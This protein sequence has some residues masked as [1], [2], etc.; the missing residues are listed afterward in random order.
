MNIATQNSRL[1]IY[2]AL[3]GSD[4]DDPV[5]DQ[6]SEL[7]VAAEEFCG[8]VNPAHGRSEESKFHVKDQ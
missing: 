4:G 5:G 7:G 8:N 6:A 3:M 1:H 2:R